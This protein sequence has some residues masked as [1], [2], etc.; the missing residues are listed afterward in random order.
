MIWLSLSPVSGPWSLAEGPR[1]APSDPVTLVAGQRSP[2]ALVLHGEHLYW[3]TGGAGESDGEVKRVRRSGGTP[4][5]VA[6]G[7]AKPSGLVVLTPEAG[8][9]GRALWV[10]D[11]TA[12]VFGS[13]VDGSTDPALV[14]RFEGT[15]G[16]LAALNG[17]IYW[18]T[19][20]GFVLRAPL[21][22]GAPEVVA[23]GERDPSAITAA[24]DAVLWIDRDVQAGSYQIVVSQGGARAPVVT[25]AGNAAWLA[26]DDTYVY[27]TVPGA[28]KER[29]GMVLRARWRSGVASSPEVIAGNQPFPYAIA[30]DGDDVYWTSWGDATIQRGA[31]LEATTQVLARGQAFPVAIAVDAGNVY[32][33]VAGESGG[34]DGEGPAVGAIRRVSR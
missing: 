31:A 4:E 20:S 34:T 22:G 12:S 18:A 8:D 7:Q 16:A 19:A 26:A 13:L 15:R 32:W 28:L 10:S 5:Q 17:Q 24:G 9:T 1:P 2:R 14:S 6:R 11:G 23:S 27:W 21:R 29:Q 30:V 25:A 33:A 3:T